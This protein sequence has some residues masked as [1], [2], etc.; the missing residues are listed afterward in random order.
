MDPCGG[1]CGLLLC[2]FRLGHC[3][4]RAD[5]DGAH[6]FFPAFGSGGVL[7]LS[8]LCTVGAAQQQ[9][10]ASGADR[11]STA[12]GSMQ[13][14]RSRCIIGSSIGSS[15]SQQPASSGSSAGTSDLSHSR[16]GGWSD[17]FSV[18]HTRCC[19][20]HSLKPVSP[21]RA[22]CQTPASD[23]P[24]AAAPQSADPSAKGL[25]L[26]CA[27]DTCRV[28]P[29]RGAR[30]I[31]TYCLTGDQEL[32]KP[33]RLGHRAPQVADRTLRRHGDAGVHDIS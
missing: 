27:A 20:F 4:C 12:S 8:G 6:R 5:G 1:G 21:H 16:A 30:T 32:P 11:H 17:L 13:R 26:E 31:T 19:W 2:E 18:P 24:P 14:S 28:A 22:T 7:L 9:C 15:S 10:C 25:H 33:P 23:R 29:S 3:D